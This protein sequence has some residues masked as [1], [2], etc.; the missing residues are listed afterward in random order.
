MIRHISVKD[1]GYIFI[2]AYLIKNYLIL[3]I[4]KNHLKSPIYSCI[5]LNLKN[6]INFNDD[7]SNRKQS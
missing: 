2:R 3:F 4:N 1:L 7:E 5:F 6:L